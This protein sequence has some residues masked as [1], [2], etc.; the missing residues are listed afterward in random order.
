MAAAKGSGSLEVALFLDMLMAER[1]ASA[2]TIEAYTRD[3]SE[4]LGFL[5][6]KGASACLLYTSPSPRDRS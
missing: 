3:L 2:H 5:A 1:G 4:F 6:S